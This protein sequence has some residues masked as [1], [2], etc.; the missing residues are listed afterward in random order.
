[1]N[2]SADPDPGVYPDPRWFWIIKNLDPDLELESPESQ[3]DPNSDSGSRAEI[4]T[5]LVL[6]IRSYYTG[7]SKDLVKRNKYPRF[8]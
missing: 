3:K 2:S 4:V 6:S 7:P 5:P 1:M 8:R